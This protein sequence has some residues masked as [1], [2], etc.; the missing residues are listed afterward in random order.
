[1]FSLHRSLLYYD[2]CQKAES[3]Q[4]TKCFFL[5]KFKAFI[6]D[7]LSM[8]RKRTFDTIMVENSA[9]KGEKC[10]LQRSFFS[11]E[12]LDLNQN[13]YLFKLTAFPEGEINMILNWN[14]VF[15]KVNNI[16]EKE[17]VLLKSI[18][19]FSHSVFKSYISSKGD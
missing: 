5:A 19:Y 13:F 1:M 17:T 6:D 16:F 2:L 8:N 7:K 12:K 15:R 11:A 10:R 18:F 4:T 14:F 3:F 9:E